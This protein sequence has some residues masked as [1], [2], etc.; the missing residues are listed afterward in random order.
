VNLDRFVEAQGGGGYERALAEIRSGRKRSHW[1]WFIFPQVAGL[2]SSPTSVYY[3]IG[4]RAEASAYLTHPVLGPRLVE[5]ADALLAHPASDASAIFGYPD[6]LKL[7]SSMTLFSE[8][9]P[10]GSVFQR[11]IDRYYGGESDQA[12]LTRIGGDHD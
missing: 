11:V 8:V 2:G 3:S 4:D 6:D 1:M 7:R 9:S 12:T 10:P 5:C